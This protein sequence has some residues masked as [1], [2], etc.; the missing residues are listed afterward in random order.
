MDALDE[1]ANA[2]KQFI[3]FNGILENTVVMVAVF[4]GLCS[5]IFVCIAWMLMFKKKQWSH[6]L[7]NH[8]IMELQPNVPQT[9][10]NDVAGGE[11]EGMYEVPMQPTLQ[12]VETLGGPQE[13]IWDDSDDDDAPLPLES[14]QGIIENGQTPQRPR[15]AVRVVSTSGYDDD[16][17]EDDDDDVV[18]KELD[19]I[20]NMHANVYRKQSALSISDMYQSAKNNL[21]EPFDDNMILEVQP[22]ST[23][24]S[25][26]TP[27]TG[28]V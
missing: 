11:E 10:T 27:E 19:I 1:S 28:K 14:T 21:N 4:C 9:Q 22:D 16:D 24:G 5:C 2:P 15:L 3:D 17:H 23:K 26:L 7:R 25:H 8:S 6:K 12:K 20:A 18:D 13:D